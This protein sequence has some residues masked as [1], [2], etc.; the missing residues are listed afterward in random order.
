MPTE[1]SST[2]AAGVRRRPHPQPADAR[3]AVHFSS[4]TAEW[5]T[6]QWL[7][8]AL[9]RE[10]AFTLD[11]CCTPANAKCPKHFTRAE[12]GLLQSWSGEVV[13]MNPPYGSDI[14]KW[15]AKA[16]DSARH[17][18]AT[19]V[20]LV[21]ARTDTAWWHTYAMKHE[22]RLLRGRLKFGEAHHCAP[23]PSAVIVMRPAA[24]TLRSWTMRPP[25]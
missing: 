25:A 9:D 2:I 8:D 16:H 14:G 5:S 4:Q 12:N 24:F 3:L 11:P 7:F 17:E 20:C 13:F 15:V 18:A 19:V 1:H 21:P 22:I 10:F 23:F 6:P